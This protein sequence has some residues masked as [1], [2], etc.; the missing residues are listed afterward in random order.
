MSL[1]RE[2][3][4]TYHFDDEARGETDVLRLKL[5]AREAVLDRRGP[6]V[7]VLLADHLLQADLNL[8]EEMLPKDDSTRQEK[9]LGGNAS[10]QD[11]LIRRH[12]G[13]SGIRT[14][15][16]FKGALQSRVKRALY[17]LRL[18]SRVWETRNYQAVLVPGIPSLALLSCSK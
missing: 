12:P 6:G 15:D 13:I 14:I 4:K 17:E 11:S 16:R 1:D 8:K 5:L 18:R 3:E 2:R 10:D 7:E 9:H